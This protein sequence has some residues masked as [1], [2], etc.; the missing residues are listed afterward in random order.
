MT[1]N[2]PR[3]KPPASA[4]GPT[5]TEG[6]LL[7]DPQYILTAEYWKARLIES[8]KPL[9]GTAEYLKERLLAAGQPVPKKIPPYDYWT[10]AGYPNVE[11]KDDRELHEIV[12]AVGPAIPVDLTGLPQTYMSGKRLTLYRTMPETEYKAIAEWY[13]TLK[14]KTE[15]FI[16]QGRG[17]SSKQIADKFRSRQDVGLMPIDGHIGDWRQASSYEPGTQSGK[18]NEAKVVVGFVMKPEVHHLLFTPPYMAIQVAGMK[19]AYVAEYSRH[20]GASEVRAL[21]FAAAT[22]NEGAK[23]GYIGLKSESREGASFSLVMPHPASK[24]LFQLFVDQIVKVVGTR[25]VPLN[26]TW[27]EGRGWA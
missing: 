10:E 12:T 20:L 13:F 27:P 11:A 1:N 16:R 7:A 23:K 4:P 24:L 21:K 19:N 3:N 15:I 26:S 9:P 2:L 5:R 6:R 14:A 17:G 22:K 25:L 18:S 8:G